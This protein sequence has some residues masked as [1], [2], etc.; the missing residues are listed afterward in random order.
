MAICR[1]GAF[2]TFLFALTIGYSAVA[3][4]GTRHLLLEQRTLMT[5]RLETLT[6]D[7]SRVAR[8]E[9]DLLTAAI[10]ALDAD[11]FASYNE[12]VSRLSAQS[13]KRVVNDRLLTAFALLCCVIAIVSL[14]LLWAAFNRFPTEQR[15]GLIALFQDL[16]KRLLGLGKRSEQM[17]SPSTVR[18]HPIVIIGVLGMTLSIV[19]YL[20]NRLF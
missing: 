6:T 7:T 2:L 16:G 14:L 15:Q 20:V 18:T 17:E 10:I 4:V 12:S 13:G 11:I 5:N 8:H 9:A 1:P 19:T 3:D